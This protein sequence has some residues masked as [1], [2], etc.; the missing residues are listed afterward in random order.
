MKLDAV[1]GSLSRYSS[2]VKVPDT[3][4]DTVKV[5]VGLAEVPGTIGLGAA[6]SSG[7]TRESMLPKTEVLEPNS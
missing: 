3:P 6:I 5:A 7:D 1:M 2:A 4:P